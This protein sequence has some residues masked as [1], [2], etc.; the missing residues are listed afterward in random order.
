MTAGVCHIFDSN[1]NVWISGQSA[2]DSHGWYL[3]FSFDC[4][5]EFRA[6]ILSVGEKN[7]QAE[8]NILTKYLVYGHN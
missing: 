1:I 6:K 7:L 5:D 2:E 8:R 3:W 4:F